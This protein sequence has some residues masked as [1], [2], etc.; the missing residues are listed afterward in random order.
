LSFTSI[1]AIGVRANLPRRRGKI[2]AHQAVARIERGEIQVS[3]EFLRMPANAVVGDAG[4]PWPLT[5]R[6]AFAV[7]FFQNVAGWS[8]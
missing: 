5:R 2:T 6:L 3:R 7:Q 4:R 1:D 8:S